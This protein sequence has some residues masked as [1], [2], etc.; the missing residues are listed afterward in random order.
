MPGY[1]AG[2]SARESCCRRSQR[3]V[4]ADLDGTD[5]S[6]VFRWE[7]ERKALQCGSGLIAGGHLLGL[8]PKAYIPNYSEFYEARHF[9]GKRQWR[10]LFVY[11]GEDEDRLFHLAVQIFCSPVKT[12]TGPE[13][14]SGDLRRS[15]G[16]KSAQ[17]LPCACTGATVIVNLSASDETTGKDSYTGSLGD[18]TVRRDWYA[19]ISTPAQAKE[20]PSRIWYS[21]A[22]HLIAE[23]GTVLAE[24]ETFYQRDYLCRP[25]YCN[26]WWESRR[27]YTTFDVRLQI[28]MLIWK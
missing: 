11:D 13:G 3:Q 22:H 14:G 25:G 10:T 12:M 2:K 6:W 4:K 19:A 21:G 27:H 1:S 8:V 26:V 9:T 15:V 16:A 24:S 7:N 18:R 28:R 17:H 23:N 5:S 20:N